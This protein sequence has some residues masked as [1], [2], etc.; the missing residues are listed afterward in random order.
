MADEFRG[1]TMWWVSVPPTKQGHGSGGNQYC[2]RLT[3]DQHH[4]GLVVNEYL[5]RVRR[6][7]CDVMFQNRCRRLYTNKKSID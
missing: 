4:R 1:A 3:F 2:L 7:G 6:S 5:P